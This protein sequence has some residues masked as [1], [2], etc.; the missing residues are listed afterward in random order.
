M[1]VNSGSNCPKN[2]RAS[3]RLWNE[4]LDLGGSVSL[5]T[6]GMGVG[7]SRLSSEM[8]TL[9]NL[10]SSSATLSSKTEP[11]ILCLLSTLFRVIIVTRN[12]H[13]RGGCKIPIQQEVTGVAWD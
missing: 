3:F 4:S 9:S 11:V 2:I 12:R 6:G 7:S 1:W 13:G 10:E 5:Q 8:E